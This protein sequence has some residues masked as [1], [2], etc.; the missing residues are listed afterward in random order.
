MIAAMDQ[1]D[2][3]VETLRGLGFTQLESLIYLHLLASGPETGY[4]IAKAI[5]KPVANTYKGVESLEHKGAVEVEEGEPRVVRASAPSEVIG[6]LRRG[7]EQRADAAQRELARLGEPAGDERVYQIGAAAQVVE[8]ARR[9]LA[10]AQG[11]VVID[12][13]PQLVRTLE[14][15][16]IACAKR[17]VAVAA[18]V[19]EQVDLPGCQVIVHTEGTLVVQLFEGQ[20]LL[21]SSD[22][23]RALVALLDTL[24]ETRSPESWPEQG[25]V[26]QAIYTASPFIA[27]HLHDNFHHQLYTYAVREALA[28]EPEL[29]ARLQQVYNER[30]RNLAPLRTRGLITLLT[31]HGSE[32]A[33]ALLRERLG[34][35]AQ[36]ERA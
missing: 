10:E 24:D 19:Y 20:H 13:F 14:S 29:R 32:G 33:L 23:E 5:G 25:G 4:A 1:S 16:L 7:F 31:R 21:L 9:M 27:R 35:S 17:G 3:P 11:A 34:A 8:R 22:A 36:S 30:L 26:R 15:D 28:D 12:A 18:L 6:R 2:T